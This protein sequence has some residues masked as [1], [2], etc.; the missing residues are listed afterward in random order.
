M[1]I[2]RYTDDGCRVWFG[3]TTGE[4][5]RQDL[6]GLET[7]GERFDRLVEIIARLV[8]LHFGTTQAR[9]DAIGCVKWGASLQKEES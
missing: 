7:D 1:N 9:L 3:T 5:L 8:D 6:I 4:V 2:E